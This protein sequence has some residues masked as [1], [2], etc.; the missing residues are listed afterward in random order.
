[1][2]INSDRLTADDTLSVSVDVTNTGERDG[3]EIVQFYIRDVVGSI[4]R[5]VK[6]LKAFK[7]VFIKAGETK[8][9]TA[10]IHVS[11]MG[12]YNKKL[13][14]VVENGKFIAYVGGNSRDTI[15]K[16]F[17]VIGGTEI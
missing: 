4:V 7:K 8:T 14:Y 10:D 2:R 11:D 3:E 5:P 1:M 17:N 12:F 15:E 6:E 16:E 13:E 9:V